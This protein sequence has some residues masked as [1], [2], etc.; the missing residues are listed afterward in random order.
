MNID[1]TSANN[2]TFDFDRFFKKNEHGIWRSN[3]A[4]QSLSYPNDG[5]TN[6]L[7]VE[8]NSLWFQH[9]NRCLGEI[10]SVFP[11][12]G[13]IFD[14]G[15]G[16]GVVSTYLLDKG[17]DCCL[18]EPNPI[19]ALNAR[20]RGLANV[21]CGTS[22]DL[23]PFSSTIPAIGLFDVLEH[24]E[25]DA[26]FLSELYNLL[27]D[28][29]RLYLTVPAHKWLWSRADKRAQ[30]YRRYSPQTLHRVLEQAGFEIEY[31]TGIFAPL[32]H[33]IFLFRSLL[34]FWGIIGAD[35]QTAKERHKEHGTS[36]SILWRFLTRLL[37][38]DIHCIHTKKIS[39]GASLLCSARKA[40]INNFK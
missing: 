1:S 15:G 34:S 23:L 10:I 31:L 30:H 2:S 27:K 35:K 3:S 4:P 33:C 28:E 24:I 25:D 13:T 26:N 29:G 21:I 8:D 9:R 39:I 36:K 38:H 32:I 20:D 37:K 17:H 40:K 18:I 14:I 7:S 6:C 16:N 19:G 12:A 22:S 11:P 5:H